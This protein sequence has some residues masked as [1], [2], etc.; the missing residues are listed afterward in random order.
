MLKGIE[1]GMEKIASM[2]SQKS[3]LAKEKVKG[4]KKPG[5]GISGFLKKKPKLIGKGM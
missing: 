1:P 2:T 5:K 4:L 3:G